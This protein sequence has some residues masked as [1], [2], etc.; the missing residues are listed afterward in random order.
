MITGDHPKISGSVK[1]HTA[2]QAFKSHAHVSSLS[3]YSLS[4][5]DWLKNMSASSGKLNQL[6][7]FPVSCLKSACAHVCALFKH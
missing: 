2:G 4:G 3:I 6:G 5:K 1:N 7:S